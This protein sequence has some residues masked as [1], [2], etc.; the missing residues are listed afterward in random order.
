MKAVIRISGDRYNGYRWEIVSSVTGR[1]VKESGPYHASR[2]EN[3][4]QVAYADAEDYARR[5][6]IEVIRYA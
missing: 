4:K 3:A 6:G 5:N 2:P 1:T